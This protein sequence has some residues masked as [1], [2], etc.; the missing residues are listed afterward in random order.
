LH[1]ATAAGDQAILTRLVPA[2]VQLQLSARLRS[3]VVDDER[4]QR[5]TP[6]EL[7]VLARV[8]AGESNVQIARALVVSTSTVR[9][10]LEHVYEKLEVPNR[11]AATAVYSRAA[12]CGAAAGESRP[13]VLTGRPAVED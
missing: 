2:L 3:A 7:T 8:A 4:L 11:A 9:K 13:R 5:L 12:G 6:R 1:D 10:H